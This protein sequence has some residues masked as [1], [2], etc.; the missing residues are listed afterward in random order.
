DRW[1]TAVT[2][3]P[4][5]HT[6]VQRRLNELPRTATM[7]IRRLELTR[8]LTQQLTQEAIPQPTPQPTH[9]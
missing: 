5:L 7:K 9:H 3:H 2:N 6:P 1:N 8:Q 4:T